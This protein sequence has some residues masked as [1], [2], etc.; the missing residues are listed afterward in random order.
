MENCILASWI[1]LL[2]SYVTITRIYDTSNWE[3][4]PLY[5]F[6]FFSIVDYSFSIVS[7]ADP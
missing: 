2:L 1:E 7:Y 6:R 5:R 4:S 3:S